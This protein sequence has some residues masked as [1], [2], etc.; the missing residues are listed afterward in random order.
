MT[1]LVPF[2]LQFLDLLHD[3]FAFLGCQLL[4]S[5]Y[6]ALF[7]LHVGLLLAVCFG[8]GFLLRLEELVACTHKALP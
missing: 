7:L 2:L 4:Q 5:A 6:D 3:V 1:Y 8:V